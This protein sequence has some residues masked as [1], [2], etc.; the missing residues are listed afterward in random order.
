[1]LEAKPMVHVKGLNEDMKTGLLEL[2]TVTFGAG[3]FLVVW[4]GGGCPVYCWI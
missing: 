1:M 3:S 4:G 2:G